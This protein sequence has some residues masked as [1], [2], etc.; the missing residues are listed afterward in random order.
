MEN[1]NVFAKSDEKLT[2][3]GNCWGKCEKGNVGSFPQTRWT[4]AGDHIHDNR[5]R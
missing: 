2:C 5:G 1:G 4:G 3:N